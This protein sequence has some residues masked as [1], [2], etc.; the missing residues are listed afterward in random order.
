MVMRRSDYDNRM[1]AMLD[2]TT[3]YRK[4]SKDPTATQEATKIT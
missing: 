1:R 3:V 4:L 2:D